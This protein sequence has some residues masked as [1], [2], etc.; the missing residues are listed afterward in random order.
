MPDALNIPMM[1]EKELL[2][3]LE[4]AKTTYLFYPAGID[5]ETTHLKMDRVLISFLRSANYNI[6]ADYLETPECWYV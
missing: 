5:I 4:A 6:A 3:A 1:T 2:K